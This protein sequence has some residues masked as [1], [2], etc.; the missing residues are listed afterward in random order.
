MIDI[1]RFWRDKTLEQKQ[2]IKS[3]YGIKVMTYKDIQN[4][5]N[6]NKKP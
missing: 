5:Y 4:I 3:K 6:E 2:A 1:L